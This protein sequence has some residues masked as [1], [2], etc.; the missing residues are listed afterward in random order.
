M[1]AM[2]KRTGPFLFLFGLL[3][4]LLQGCYSF[5]GASIPAHLHTV[6]VPLFDDTSQ[7]GIAEFRERCTRRLIKKIEAQSDLSIEPDLSR[8]NAVLKGLILS[9]ADEP[10]QLGGSTERA[11]TNRI[12]IVLRADFEDMVKHEQL[13]SQSFVGFADY[14]AGSYLAQQGAID[15]AIDMAVD[16]L[17]NRMISNW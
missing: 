5:S 16:E 13:F 4:V 8:A 7:A 15:G 1:N 3:A 9:Y 17:F 6:A 14:Q 12:T 11:V 10:S 2:H